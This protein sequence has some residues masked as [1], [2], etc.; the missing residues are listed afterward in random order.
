MRSAIAGVMSICL[1]PNL[2]VP[3]P[4]LTL[5]R[6]CCLVIGRHIIVSPDIIA[7]VPF[8]RLLRHHPRRSSRLRVMS[9][10]P[11][12]P[13]YLSRNGE[14]LLND[15]GLTAGYSDVVALLAC[16]IPFPASCNLVLSPVAI[17]CGLAASHVPTAGACDGSVR[18]PF[19][20]PHLS[21]SI[22]F[23]MLPCQSLKT[24]RL[25]DMV[26][27]C[28]YRD[29]PHPVASPSYP[30]PSRRS[31]EDCLRPLRRRLSIPHAVIRPRFFSLPATPH[32]IR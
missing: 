24:L 9:S 25:F 4:P 26:W 2:A 1:L 22:V 12:A 23:K 13:P 18:S 31:R 14:G 17:S 28:E 20:L 11:L 19:L 8:A 27:I 6:Y 3:L 29:V 16:L 10:P 30:V 21:V 15:C 5:V 7:V 32:P